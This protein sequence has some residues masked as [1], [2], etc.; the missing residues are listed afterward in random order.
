[1]NI[2]TLWN[3]EPA[4]VVGFVQAVL[5][6]A[7]SFGLELTAEQTGGILVVVAAALSLLVRRKVS[8]VV[9]VPTEPDVPANVELGAE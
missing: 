3:R 2:S 9:K 7:L 1:M 5:G 4:L 8:P 6:L